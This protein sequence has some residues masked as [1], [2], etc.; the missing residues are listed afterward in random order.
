ML[1]I[2]ASLRDEMFRHARSAAPAEACGM[3]IAP[4]G[5]AFPLRFEPL[6]NVAADARR[7]FETDPLE[8]MALYREM[9]VRGEDPVA[10]VHS[11]VA[12]PAEPS[13]VDLATAVHAGMRY[14][15]LS[16]APEEIRC[17][18]ISD[19]AAEEEVVEV[20]SPDSP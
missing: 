6:R 20:V 1:T 12:T 14:V 9:D 11:H 15:I 19:G 2:T 18:F 13:G 8:V 3:L 16:L 17:W 10:I 5:Y 4:M 7:F